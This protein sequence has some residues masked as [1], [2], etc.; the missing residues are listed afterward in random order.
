ML[1]F[2][3]GRPVAVIKGGK[4]DGKIIHVS[5]LEPGAKGGEDPK[6]IKNVD[7]SDE[8]YDSESDYEDEDDIIIN[9]KGGKMSIYDKNY[10]KKSIYSK[11]K[12][13]D[14]FFKK[15]YE[16]KKKKMAE[17]SKTSFSIHDGVMQLLP[18]KKK[19]Q[20][21]ILYVAGP[22]GAGKSTFV[23]NYI[24]Q[25][26]IDFPKRKVFVFS[27]VANDDKI[28][29]FKPTRIKLDEELVNDPIKGEELR[30][31]LVIFDDVDTIR[32]KKLREAVIGLRDDLLETGRHED[33]YMANTSHQ[34]TNYKVTRT[35]LNESNLVTFFPYSSG[36]KGIDYFLKHYCGLDSK[37]VKKITS[38]PSRWVTISKSYPMFVL[39]SSGI[40]LLHKS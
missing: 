22:S 37:Q 7:V 9:P 33:V 18:L 3:K 4:Y 36:T 1:S 14:K 29:K 32:D 24:E 25:F 10:I 16:D 20:R 6:E 27:T 17:M 40:F 39:Y 11:T 5:D 8:E 12:P 38:L 34:I 28:D 31:S 2:T 21:D 35:L 30:K 23:A 13:K 15:V 19:E 26:K